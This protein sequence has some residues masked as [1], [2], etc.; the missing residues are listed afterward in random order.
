MEKKN[1]INLLAKPFKNPVTLFYAFALLVFYAVLPQSCLASLPWETPLSMVKESITGP[2]AGYAASIALV[3]CGLAYA[4]GEGGQFG[5]K[6]IQIIIGLCLA[7]L[8]ARFI[9]TLY[10]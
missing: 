8:S 6:G 1:L 7:L 3:C 5:R 9:S 4:F 2:V 10:Q